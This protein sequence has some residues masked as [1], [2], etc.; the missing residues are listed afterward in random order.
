MN[1]FPKTTSISFGANE[2][3]TRKSIYSA[4][5]VRCYL[6]ANHFKLSDVFLG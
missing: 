2:E 5:G 1:D 4:S 6:L 3:T